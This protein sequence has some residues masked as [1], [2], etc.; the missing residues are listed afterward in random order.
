MGH[1]SSQ[2]NR[3]VSIIQTLGEAYLARGQYTEA[4]EKFKQLVKAGSKA[5][6][7]HR[8]LALSYIALDDI[9]TPAISSYQ[10]ALK[11]FPHDNQLYLE[12][13]KVLLEHKSIDDFS[14]HCYQK[15]LTFHPPFEKKIYYTFYLYFKN[16]QQ[17][18]HAFQALKQVVI[19]ER[20]KDP[21]NLKALVRISWQLKKVTELREILTHLAYHE[22]N[23]ITI[24]R[25][26]ALD[27]AYAILKKEHKSEGSR[28]DLEILNNSM[29]FYEKIRTI[30]G[31]RELSAIFLAL[32]KLNQA[33]HKRAPSLLSGPTHSKKKYSYAAD[34]QES[35]PFENSGEAILQRIYTASSIANQHYMLKPDQ[36]KGQNILVLR[37][38][39]IDELTNMVGNKLSK[40]LIKRFLDFSL[41]FLKK[42][43]RQTT[44]N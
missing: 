21:E 40:A 10:N 24:K 34:F 27:F 1:S 4:L 36:F 31:A 3:L 29:S 38:A 7:V 14:I 17:H 33:T 35:K 23:N 16:K 5:P 22:H 44:L 20:G 39:N 28:Y 25:F 26:L 18:Q 37:I 8:N 42:Q 41:N 13:C 6:E 2:G 32:L 43:L 11:F 15:V 30:T 9:S 12:V 19:M